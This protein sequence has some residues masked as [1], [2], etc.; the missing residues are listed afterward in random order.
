MGLN[1]RRLA[2]L[3]M[4]LHGPRFIVIE[5][6]LGVGGCGVIGGLSLSAGIRLLPH[7]L[8]WQLILGIWLL[9]IAL[10]YVPLLLH[11]IDLARRGKAR[12]EAATEL[13]NPSQVRR[14][15]LLQLWILVPFAIVIFALLQRA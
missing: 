12:Q 13:T 1:V 6:A 2:A 14:Y 10:N 8:S 11:A 5:F 9:C 7:G 15:G 4:A 3:D